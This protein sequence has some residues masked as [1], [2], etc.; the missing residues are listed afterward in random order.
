MGNL[1]RISIITPSYQQAAF[2]EGTIRSVLDQD[3]PDLEYIVVDG[4]S[5]DGSAAIIERYADRIAWWVSER[6]NGQAEAINKGIRRATGEVIAYLNSDDQ[7]APGT[8]RAVGEAL[9]GGVD[10]GTDRQWCAGAVDLVDR[11]GARESCW[12]PEPPPEDT[13]WLLT[14][15]WSVPQVGAFW[16]RS[17][18]ARFGVLRTDMHYGLDTDWFLRLALGG[19][20]PVL[21]ERVMGTYLLHP[22]SKTGEGCTP[23]WRDMLRYYGLYKDMVPEA[24][25]WRATYRLGQIRHD[26]ARKDGRR[27]RAWLE[28]VRLFLTAPRRTLGEYG[29]GWMH[30][31]A[32]LVQ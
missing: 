2:L 25:R 26:L 32:P 23:F 20:A 30:G 4:G 17:L 27:A 16:R 3:Y 6:D 10:G 18:H 7:Y 5:T 24:D 13:W 14:K 21:L 9:A 28:L 31:R 12:T 1:P 29:R 11:N 8:L 15:P 19:C 22:A